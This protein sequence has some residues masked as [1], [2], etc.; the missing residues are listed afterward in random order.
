MHSGA[1]A[2]RRPLLRKIILPQRDITFRGW[3]WF[4]LLLP[5]CETITTTSYVPSEKCSVSQGNVMFVSSC[6]LESCGTNALKG[7][8]FWAAVA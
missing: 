2:V 7:D 5:A 1:A 3:L 8:L 6:A 4:N